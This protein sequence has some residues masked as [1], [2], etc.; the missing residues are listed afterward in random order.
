MGQNTKLWATIAAS[1]MVPAFL[2]GAM[3]YFGD[4]HMGLPWWQVIAGGVCAGGLMAW[5]RY[6]DPPE[7]KKG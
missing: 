5:H 6:A 4:G 7:K 2:T 1:G 3:I